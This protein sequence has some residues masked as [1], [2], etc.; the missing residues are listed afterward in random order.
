LCGGKMREG[1][2]VAVKHIGSQNREGG[3][4]ACEGRRGIREEGGLEKRWERFSVE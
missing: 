2:C 1:L 3:E 4:G